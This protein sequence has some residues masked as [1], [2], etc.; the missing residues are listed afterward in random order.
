M[1]L[2]NLNKNLLLIHPKKGNIFL[3]TINLLKYFKLLLISLTNNFDSYIS[4]FFILYIIFISVN[5]FINLPI[6]SPTDKFKV[7]SREWWFN[8]LDTKS[9]NKKRMCIIC[10]ERPRKRLYCEECKINN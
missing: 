1:K 6:K 7:M 5:G 2:K 4:Y 8:K 3:G 9:C 10:K